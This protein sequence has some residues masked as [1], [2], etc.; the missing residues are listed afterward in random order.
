MQ[1]NYS[2][3]TITRLKAEKIQDEFEKELKSRSEKCEIDWDLIPLEL[4]VS[5]EKWR[6]LQK[7]LNQIG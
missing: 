5:S 3:V 1:N 7:S 4:V 6:T 2:G